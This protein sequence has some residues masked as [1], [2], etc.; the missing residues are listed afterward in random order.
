[1]VVQKT[2]FEPLEVH[3]TQEDAFDVQNPGVKCV[4]EDVLIAGSGSVLVFV[5]AQL[6]AKNKRPVH[7]CVALACFCLSYA[8]FYYWTN[9]AGLLFFPAL[10]FSDISVD[11]LAASSV[12]VAALTVLSEGK[13]PVR[14][15]AIRFVLPG[16]FALGFG[17]YNAMTAGPLLS[18]SGR[19]PDRFATPALMPMAVLS[20]L[21]D[22]VY[23]LAMIHGLAAALHIK[24]AGKVTNP[25]GFRS[26][27]V[28]LFLFLGASMVRMSSW[29]V[30]NEGPLIG[31]LMAFCP[32]VVGFALSKIEVSYFRRGEAASRQLRSPGSQQWDV[33]AGDLTSKLEGLMNNVAPYRNPSL[34][35]KQ[36]AR[37]LDVEPK[38]LTYHL[39]SK[40]ATN[41]CTYV[42]EWRLKAVARDLL[43]HPEK[44]ILETA[45]ANG[46]NSKSSFNTLFA[47]AY[48]ATPR[49]FRRRGANPTPPRSS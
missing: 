21:A 43:Q 41:F 7:Y 10:A 13:R 30:G 16:L 25:E 9:L 8:L 26:Q 17:L 11:L 32:I 48:G 4:M 19:L 24:R 39:H 36:L 23:G 37:M 2:F 31:G 27:V 5:V 6:V 3:F 14:N 20:F 49:D 29:L 44:T 45:F 46:F 42:N 28:F 22:L 35:L 33:G 47:K 18:G 40:R 38:R 34:T 15:L 12:N 1:M